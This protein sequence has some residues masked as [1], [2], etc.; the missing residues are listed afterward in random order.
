MITAIKAAGQAIMKVYAQDFTVTEKADASPLTLADQKSHDILTA[1]LR[2]RYPFP[3]LSEE[4]RDIPYG[5]RAQWETFW[6]LDPLDG[7]KEFVNR[8]GEFTINIALINKG[9]PAIGVIYV[10]INDV[11]YYA[12][13]GQGAYKVERGATTRLPLSLAPRPSRL[14]VVGS[15]SHAGK[16]LQDYLA[17]L[18]EKFGDLDFISAG[19]ALKFCLVAEGKADL[20]PRLGPTMEWDTAAGQLIVEEAGGRVIETTG[21]AALRYNKEKLVNPNFIVYRRT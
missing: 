18:R 21:G 4:G 12:S 5:E 11:L 3:I 20:Y 15:R 10:P 19:S 13:I 7:T 16:E 2:S 1:Y 14:T 8:N 6:L 9:K 17:H